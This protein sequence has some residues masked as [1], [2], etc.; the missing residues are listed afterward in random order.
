MEA[1]GNLTFIS[2]LQAHQTPDL[3]WAKDQGPWQGASK[4]TNQMTQS[5]PTRWLS[6][7]ELQ[8]Q[9]HYHM[10]DLGRE[11]R[12]SL[13]LFE[14]AGT[15]AWS[16]QAHET[17]NL[18]WAKDQGPWQGASK[19]TNHLTQSRPTRSLSTRE[20]Q[21]QQHCHMLDL[22]RE[23]TFPPTRAD[24]PALAWGQPDLQTTNSVLALW[25]HKGI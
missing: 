17:P 9:Q 14:G 18:A 24:D 20:L 3:A 6:T 1:Q 21:P 13:G 7:R 4:P 15:L 2:S 5:R 19:P 16:L 10:L 8:L 23:A 22:G 25:K 11:A 12:P